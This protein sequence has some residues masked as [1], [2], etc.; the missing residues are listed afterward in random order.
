MHCDGRRLGNTE[1]IDFDGGGA[2]FSAWS[3]LVQDQTLGLFDRLVIERT[4]SDGIHAWYRCAEAVCGNLK[5][6]QRPGPD[7]RPQA[8]IETRGEGGLVL[9]DPSPGYKLMQGSLTDL[10]VLTAAER[11]ILLSAAWSLNEYV[12]DVVDG[13]ENANVPA[14]VA[15]GQGTPTTA[16]PGDDFNARGDVRGVLEAHGWALVKAGENEYWRRPGKTAGWSA[17]FKDR[18]FYVFSS[19]A[20]PFEPHKGYSPFAVYT[21]LEHN[22]D[23]GAAAN[24]LR[25][26]GYGNEIVANNDVDLSAFDIGKDEVPEEPPAIDD[27]GPLPETMLSIPGFINEV[28]DYTMRTAPYPNLVMAFCGA[29]SLQA[30]LAGRKV[31]DPG[32]NRT[33]LYVLALAN[34]GAG[35]DHPRKVNQRICIEA[36]LQTAMGDNFASGEGIEDRLFVTP[37]MLFQTDEIDGLMNA[38]NKAGDSRHESIMNVLLKMYT[39]SNAMYPMRVK[40][41]KQVSGVI[42]QPSLCLLGTAVPKYYY[43]AL[44]TRML[45][46]GFF[47]RMIILDTGKRPR[48]QRPKTLAIPPAILATARYWSQLGP[49]T[50]D[51]AN[52]HPTPSVVEQDE[53]AA[54]ALDDFRAF[55]DDRYA[56]A[57]EKDDLAAM[58]VWARAYEKACKL[59]LV[60][61]VSEH[62]LQPRIRQSATRWACQFVDHQ[63]RQMLFM[64]G[65]H[66]ADGEFDAR[67]KRM[68]EVLTKWRARRGDTWMPHWNLSRSMSWSDRD[69]EEVV[70]ALIGQQK[71]ECMEGSTTGGGPRARRYRLRVTAQLPQKKAVTGLAEG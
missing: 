39:A 24:R 64:A 3:E 17:T 56:E 10:P 32:D 37:S 65:Q 61:A 14:H 7:G 69:L 23:F 4:Q 45:N 42:D 52:W 41:G 34:S 33:N 48:G 50:G 16:R 9:C 25:E 40:A 49:G 51:L 58:A 19:N 67:C 22:G 26:L 38:I 20:A 44:S 66:V 54:S 43:Q 31:S 47:A 15:A 46:N 2:L 21:W 62:A 13:P 60:Y 6:A 12:P 63:T 8:L 30:F 11:D 29:L 68:L 55:A 27:P 18:V 35:K 36:G 71:I 5:L 53:K 59:A 70:S 1:A 28:L 57:E